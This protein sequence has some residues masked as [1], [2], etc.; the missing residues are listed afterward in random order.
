LQV[1]FRTRKLKRRYQQS[2]E[3]VRAWGAKVG[4][5]Y[6]ERINII[7]QVKSI[8]DLAS[9]PALHFHEL[10]GERAGQYAINLTEYDRL[11]VRVEGQVVIIEEVGGHYGD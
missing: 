4:R 9:L 3:A 8:E 7:K 6:I 10:K 2:D 11:I 1:D 5:K